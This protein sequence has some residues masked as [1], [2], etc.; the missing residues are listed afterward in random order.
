[1]PTTQSKLSRVS[2]GFGLSKLTGS[3]RNR[4]ESG[5]HK[6]SLSTQVHRLVLLMILELCIS[7]FSYSVLYNT[8]NTYKRMIWMD[9]FCIFALGQR[10]NSDYGV[11]SHFIMI[12]LHYEC[13]VFDPCHEWTWDEIQILIY[14][15]TVVFPNFFKHSVVLLF[16]VI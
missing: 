11:F 6:H 13:C 5:L 10:D 4:K 1:M 2:S 7:K 16:I 3:R 9:S 15:Q 8:L 14:C 12:Q